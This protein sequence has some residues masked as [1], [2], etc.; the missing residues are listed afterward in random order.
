MAGGVRGGFV[1]HACIDA[2]EGRRDVGCPATMPCVLHDDGTWRA[3]LRPPPS[4]PDLRVGESRR[5][6]CLRTTEAEAREARAPGRAATRSCR[7]PVDAARGPG[8]ERSSPTI[9]PTASGTWLRGGVAERGSVRVAPAEAQGPTRL[10]AVPPHPPREPAGRDRWRPVDRADETRS[11][12]TVHRARPLEQPTQR[13][14]TSRGSDLLVIVAK[15][16]IPR[17][18]S[19]ASRTPPRPRPRRC[20]LVASASL[21]LPGAVSRRADSDDS[22][23]AFWARP[24]CLS[25]GLGECSSPDALQRLLLPPTSRRALRTRRARAPPPASTGKRH[26]RRRQP[27]RGLGPERAGRAEG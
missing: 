9:W 23:H 5:G 15:V 16:G 21:S 24:G 19:R 4:G 20:G 3:L 6:A 12:R 2:P 13:Q 14:Q 26:T 25:V 27:R 7:P 22:M 18:R 8:S 11:A 10:R 17:T 1:R